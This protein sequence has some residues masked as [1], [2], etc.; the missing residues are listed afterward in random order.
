MNFNFGY[1]IGVFPQIIS[2]LP[3][4]LLIA[5]VSIFFS[6]LLGLI[7]ALVRVQKFP[8][9]DQLLALYISFFRAMPSVVLLFIVYYGSPQI[10]P[11]LTK[12][13]AITAASTPPHGMAKGKFHGGVTTMVP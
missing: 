5:V 1:F 13:P 8:I 2:Y 10:F 9:L 3:T 11:A 6:I 4:T 7:I 12:M